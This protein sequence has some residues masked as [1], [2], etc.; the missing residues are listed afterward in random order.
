LENNLIIDNKL[1]KVEDEAKIINMLSGAK[2]ARSEVF[3]W[4]IAAGSKHLGNVRIEAIRKARR[5]FCIVACDGHEKQVHELI[6]GLDYIDLYIPES[7]LL[8]RCRVKQADLSNRYYLHFAEFVAQV[9]R[10]NNLRVNVQQSGDVKIAFSKSTAGPRQITQ[11]FMKNCFDISTG[12]FS[13]YVSRVESKFFAIHDPIRAVEIKSGDWSAKVN[14]EV[15]LVKE[16]EP[17]EYNGLTYK[18]WRICCRFSQIDQISKK[19]L[20]R[21]ILD[22][23]KDEI[24]VINK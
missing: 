20:E 24:H 2:E 3:I 10:R 8:L 22:R 7:A 14:A 1:K 21:F 12:G 11:Q 5:D 23:I 13:F 19:Y 9:E 4:R 17:D 18:V 16:I 6:G 15:S